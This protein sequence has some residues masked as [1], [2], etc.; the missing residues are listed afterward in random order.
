L[1]LQYLQAVSITLKFGNL[2]LS[3]KSTNIMRREKKNDNE[4]PPL[5]V[6]RQF[7]ALTYSNGAANLIK[8]QYRLNRIKSFASD[9]GQ[10]GY[11]ERVKGLFTRISILGLMIF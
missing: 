11:Y 3:C 2:Q 6:A 9:F 7:I 4:H 10:K 5:F 8:N 1:G